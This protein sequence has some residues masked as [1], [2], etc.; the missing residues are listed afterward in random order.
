VDFYNKTLSFSKYR[1]LTLRENTTWNYSYYPIIFEIEEDLIKVQKE[2]NRIKIFPRRYF[3]PSLNKLTYVQ[4]SEML[5]SESISSRI[6]C[7]PLSHQIEQV[8]IEKICEILNK[9]S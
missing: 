6:L 7:L 2:L 4:N 3:Y 8:V 1:T 5:I 9:F